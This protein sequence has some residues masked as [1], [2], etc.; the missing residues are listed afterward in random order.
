[1][2]S[3]PAGL[4]PFGALTTEPFLLKED[5]AAL[6][7]YYR[8]APWLI[9]GAS[10][11]TVPSAGSFVAL[12]A[13][14]RVHAAQEAFAGFDDPFFNKAQMVRGLKEN[15]AQRAGVAAEGPTLDIR[16]IRLIKNGNLDDQR[17]VS[18]RIDAL[19]RLPDTAE[20]L[21]SL[22]GALG[23]DPA[24]DVYP[25]AL[26]S[27]GQ[28]KGMDLSNRRVVA[29]ASHALVPFDLD[30]LDQPAIALSAPSVTGEK[31]DGLLTMAEILDLKLDADWVVL[32]ACN[33]G[34][35]DGAGAE[36]VSGPGRAF[37]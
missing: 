7:A 10:A 24:R 15:A 27:E 3:G 37:F 29:F 20:E 12:R 23:A 6:F 34:A 9:R 32:S 18:C 5:G 11:S 21:I 14:P 33:T 17:I 25:G 22:A 2:V 35:A 19:E 28:V 8:D 30:G 4:L 26:A 16:G 13:N 1:M 31:E 36:T